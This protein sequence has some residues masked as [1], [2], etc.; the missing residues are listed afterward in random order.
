MAD[1]LVEVAV[2]VYADLPIA[3]LWPKSS[4][5]S[6]CLL[7]IGTGRTAQSDLS[8]GHSHSRE[9]A[10]WTLL[11]TCGPSRAGGTSDFLLDRARPVV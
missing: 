2:R 5:T 3:P 7:Q 8:G 6:L 1:P 11:G 4:P 10:P 9:A